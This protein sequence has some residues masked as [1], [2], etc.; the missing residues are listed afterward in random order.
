MSRGLGDV[1]K[2]QLT[3]RPCPFVLAW[4][5]PAWTKETPFLGFSGCTGSWCTGVS[6]V[7]SAF[8]QPPCEGLRLAPG[9]GGLSDQAWSEASK[10][11]PCCSFPVES[12][13]KRKYCLRISQP[14]YA[15][16]S[17]CLLEPP[18]IS[19]FR[20]HPVSMDEKPSW[21]VKCKSTSV[22]EECFSP[23]RV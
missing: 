9:R 23:G 19:F 14:R 18:E 6:C 15:R 21:P 8:Q 11:K 7:G 16:T 12:L 10:S 4:E 2:R 20:E 13:L 17:S 1:Y 22:N 5:L 3:G